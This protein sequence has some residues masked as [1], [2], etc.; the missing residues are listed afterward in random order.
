VVLATGYR[1]RVSNF[2]QEPTSVLDEDGTPI[3]TG[4][5]SAVSGLYFCGYYVSPTGMLREI[6]MEARQISKTIVQKHIK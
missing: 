3:L 5:E 2:L 6:A 1:P 4:K